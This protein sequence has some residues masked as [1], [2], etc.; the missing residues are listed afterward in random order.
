MKRVWITGAS[1]GIGEECAVEF[2]RRGDCIV[3]SGRRLSELDRVAQR[4]R[5]AGAHQVRILAFDLSDTGILE[6]VAQKAWEFF[7]GLDILYC[8]AGISQRCDT[9]EA[10]IQT[11][12]KVMEV[13]YFAPVIIT[14]A[15]LHRMLAA[16]GGQL[17]CTSSIAGLFGSRQR[18]A[19]G[20]AKAAILRFYETI[21]A[22]Y[23][24]KNIRTT[25]II[26]GRVRTNISYSALEAGGRP[27]GVLDN[28]QAKGISASKA[29]KA[30]VRAIL[31][32][33]REKLVGGMELVAVWVKRFCPA[34]SAVI[35]R[36]VKN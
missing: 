21:G 4:C 20:S 16:G 30:I 19:Y 34:L 12:R 24:D 25:V 8:N 31:R 2:A 17:A 23:H 11:I 6:D 26:P 28:G 35:S 10:D 29:A 36:K 1:S 7:G 9:D 3:I 15:I 22:E 18:C 13:D 14:K 32:G 5:D 33:R 27:H